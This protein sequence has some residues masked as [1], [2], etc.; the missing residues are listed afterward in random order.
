MSYKHTYTHL[1]SLPP[2]H[3]PP[4][5]TPH[6]RR[7]GPCASARSSSPTPGCPSSRARAPTAC[8]WTSAS[9]R[10]GV[11]PCSY[12]GA[13]SQELPKELLCCL[14]GKGSGASGSPKDGR[15][16]GGVGHGTL[17]LLPGPFTFQQVQGLRRLHLHTHTQTRTPVAQRG[18]ASL[19]C[20][21]TCPAQPSLCGV[22]PADE[23]PRA[24]E[25]LT[26]QC[27]T[28]AVLRPLCLALKALLAEQ[29]LNDASTGGLRCV[30][31]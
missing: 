2:P 24:A 17:R 12:T 28:F 27:N 19:H 10:V 6:R 20:V 13:V 31:T 5:P 21:P 8:A 7:R 16:A 15:Q 29:R 4:P 26:G 30:P 23:G 22:R 11:R 25:W 9:T 18:I 1:H 14:R 3:L